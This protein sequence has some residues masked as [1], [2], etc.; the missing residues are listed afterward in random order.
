MRPSV[1]DETLKQRA[2]AIVAGLRDMG[3]DRP[4]SAIRLS[5]R[6]DVGGN[7]EN[8]RR[9]VREAVTYARETLGQRICGN[10]DGCWLARNH[11]EWAAY[12]A[13]VKSQTVFTFVRMS[14]TSRAVAERIGGQG[15]LFDPWR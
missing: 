2:E 12:L 10:G 11:S 14:R 3:G 8:K 6:I 4:V 15:K 1:S 7:H 13:A 9:R 5:G